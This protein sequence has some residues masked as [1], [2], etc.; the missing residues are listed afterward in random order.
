[1]LRHISCTIKVDKGQKMTEVARTSTPKNK[2]SQDFTIE[3]SPIQKS[4]QTLF[5]AVLEILNI[6]ILCQD[7]IG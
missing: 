4:V 1:M 5:V 6:T 3:L 2:A 7:M